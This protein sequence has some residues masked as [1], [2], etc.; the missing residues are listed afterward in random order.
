VAGHAFL[1]NAITA[2][3]PKL[4]QGAELFIAKYPTSAAAKVALEAY[5]KFEKSGTGLAPVAG[6]GQ[7][8]FKVTDRFA[9]NVVVAQKGSYVVGAHHVRNAAA[10]LNLVKG[11]LAKVK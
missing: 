6:L 11:A 9:K 10:A 7:T 2:R 1:K 5:R 4:G 8:A 3:Y